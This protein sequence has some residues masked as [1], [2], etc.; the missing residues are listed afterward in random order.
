MCAWEEWDAC[1]VCWSLESSGAIGA[2]VSHKSFIQGRSG[3]EPEAWL[4]A[5]FK[6]ACKG[7]WCNAAYF[8]CK[9]LF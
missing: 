4:G 8:P 3:A 7:G 9:A 6:G 1:N 2:L 5:A